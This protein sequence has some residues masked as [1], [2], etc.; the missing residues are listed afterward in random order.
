M[1]NPILREEQAPSVIPACSSSIQGSCIR[2]VRDYNP[3]QSLFMDLWSVNVSSFSEPASKMLQIHPKQCYCLVKID[4]KGVHCLMMG[5]GEIQGL[6][7]QTYLTFVTFHVE[8]FL[9]CYHTHCLILSR[10]WH[11]RLTT[12]GAAW[13]ILPATH[14]NMEETMTTVVT[15]SASFARPYNSISSRGI[16]NQKI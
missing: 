6:G 12:D 7:H 2:D 3:A 10:F 5:M 16:I 1:G 14:K 4:N 11:D 13:S 9:Q 8:I 15:L